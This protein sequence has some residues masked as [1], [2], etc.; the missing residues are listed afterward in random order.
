MHL[1]RRDAWKI[2]TK[3]MV[4]CILDEC[5]GID[6]DADSIAVAGIGRATGLG[7]RH[8]RKETADVNAFLRRFAQLFVEADRD[9]PSWDLLLRRQYFDLITSDLNAKLDFGF[10]HAIKRISKPEIV[11]GANSLQSVKSV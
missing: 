1:A 5:I 3:G 9:N 4:A 10:R 8:F 7:R 6:F 11:L 2:A